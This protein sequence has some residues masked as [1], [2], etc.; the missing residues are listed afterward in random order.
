MEAENFSQ[1]LSFPD[2]VIGDAPLSG[3]G[4]LSG[5]GDINFSAKLRL[6]FL[7]SFSLPP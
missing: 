1:S 7:T 6:L 5:Q 3:T 2:S 4:G